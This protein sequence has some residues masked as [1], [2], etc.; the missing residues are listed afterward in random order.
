MIAAIADT[1]TAVWYIFADSRLSAQAKATIDEAAGNGVYVGVST[2]SL[3][4]VVYLVEKHRL[5]SGTLERLTETLKN[6]HEV[7]TEVPIDS[8]IVKYLRQVPRDQVPDLPDR[9]IAGTALRFGVPVI[10][11]DRKIKA[12][13]LQT[14]W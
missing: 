4:E 11:R 9:I 3:V 6:P 2:I 10:S 8:E 13:D 12:A 7:L 14:I 5:A 1:H